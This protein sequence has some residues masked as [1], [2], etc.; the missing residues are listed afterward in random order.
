MSCSLCTFFMAFHYIWNEIQPWLCWL[1]CGPLQQKVAGLIPGQGA[2]GRQL[3]DVSLHV[4]LSLKSI[5]ISLGK[6]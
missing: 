5:N 4:S 2:Y 3:I 6:D 1:E